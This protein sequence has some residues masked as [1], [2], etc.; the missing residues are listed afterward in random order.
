MIITCPQCDTR[1]VVPSTV[2]MKGGRKVRCASCKHT[3]F[4]EEALERAADTIN[5]PKTIQ[6]VE[7][8]SDKKGFL[9]D[10]TEGYKVIGAFAALVIVGYF[11]IQFIS[12]A[13][14]IGQGLALDNISISREG[15]NIAIKGDVVNTMDTPRGVPSI[16]ITQ[17]LEGDVAG[18]KIIIAPQKD[19]L[20]SGEAMEF[21]ATMDSVGTEIKDVKVT[22]FVGN[23][24]DVIESSESNED[25][26]AE[27]KADDSHGDAAH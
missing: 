9:S 19:I 21:N 12:P 22:F 18:D 15:Q 14:V 25:T 6:N 5:P 26:H 20:Q 23:A 11:V 2:F 13:L 8:K 16:Q 24:D 4:H 1:F 10:F 27:T 7:K 3:W 17:Y